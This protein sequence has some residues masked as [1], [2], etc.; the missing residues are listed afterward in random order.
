MRNA[1]VAIASAVS[2]VVVRGIYR[3]GSNRPDGS[4]D[5]VA[6]VSDLMRPPCLQG[7]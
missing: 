3:A 2:I 5:I 1:S 7:S 6:M 4:K